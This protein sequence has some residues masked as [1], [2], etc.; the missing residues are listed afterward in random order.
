M[1]ERDKTCPVGTEGWTRRVHF[2]RKG[3]GRGG[4]SAP[5]ARASSQQRP[6]APAAP[7]APPP[8]P[9][10]TSAASRASRARSRTRLRKG[11]ASTSALSGSKPGS[12]STRRRATAP[13]ATSS[14]I[15][16]S[17][18]S[19]SAAA[20]PAKSRPSKGSASAQRCCR[21]ARTCDT[22]R[23]QLVRRDGRDVS[24]L[25]GRE[26]GGGGLRHERAL[27]LL[28]QV[29]VTPQRR[30]RAR[31][32]RA[33]GRPPPA[34]GGLAAPFRARGAAA[35]NPPRSAPAA[36]PTP[37]AAACPSRPTRPARCTANAG[38]CGASHCT[39]ALRPGTSSPRA[40]TSCAQQDPLARRDEPMGER[41]ETRPVSTEGWTRRVHVV[42]EGGGGG[43][44]GATN[45]AYVRSR[46]FCG[47]CPCSP[48]TRSPAH[49][50]SA[51]SKRARY[52]TAAHVSTNTMVL[53]PPAPPA[54]P[55]A[56]SSRSSPSSAE[57]F[58]L[59]GTTAHELRTSCG[60]A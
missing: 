54:P 45:S 51:G 2:V 32:Q 19:P 10:P 35:R 52:S 37:P 38:S 24:T 26:G 14:F 11:I 59:C 56:R 43:G 16:G 5:A 3:R 12:S 29:P 33:G 27:R 53:C 44:G 28:V 49:S 17:R 55:A 20:S 8:P 9:P 4:G 47:I 21:Y 42:R 30:A 48:T 7:R 60:V 58:S 6:A 18:S 25:Y 34:L 13:A 50:G 31:E 46:R 40:A 22:R 23:V 1:G 57:S 39:T 41:D 36:A 15:N